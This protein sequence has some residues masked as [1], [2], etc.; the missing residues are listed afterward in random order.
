M[1]LQFVFRALEHGAVENAAFGK[2]DLTQRRGDRLGVEFAHA[3]EIDG[4]DGRPFLHHDHN[5]VVVR[6]DLHV[7][8][9]ARAVQAANGLGRFFFSEFLAH[10]NGEI[11]E[12]GAG[13]SPLNPF[14]AD[15]PHD[16]RVEGLGHGR[17]H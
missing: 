5:H 16:K 10:F 7:G 6:L 17:Q 11:T 12:D 13:V 9:K 15:I 8:E 4:G 1:L 2:T 14:Y 3:V